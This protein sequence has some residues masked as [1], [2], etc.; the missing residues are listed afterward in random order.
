MNTICHKKDTVKFDTS[1]LKIFRPRLIMY[2]RHIVIG[3]FTLNISS[4]ICLPMDTDIYSSNT[5]N[6]NFDYV[7]LEKCWDFNKLL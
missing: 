7:F 5:V 1:L 3:Y 6:L 2:N 4:T